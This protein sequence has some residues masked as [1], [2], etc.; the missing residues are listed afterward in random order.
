MSEEFLSNMHDSKYLVAE[1]NSLQEKQ[2]SKEERNELDSLIQHNKNDLEELL[3]TQEVYK[4]NGKELSEFETAKMENLRKEI[5]TLETKV[6]EANKVESILPILLEKEKES[7][8]KMTPE[9]EARQQELLQKIS[10]KEDLILYIR[11]NIEDSTIEK[12]IKQ[13]RKEFPDSE[14]AKDH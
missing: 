4:Q 10:E 3:H 8:I 5:E 13:Y 11:D 12:T 6:D 7:E 1:I 14:I 2:L 9:I